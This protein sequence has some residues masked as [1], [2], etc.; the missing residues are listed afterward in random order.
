VRERR[1]GEGHWWDALDVLD[2][3]ELADLHPVL[4]I[5]GVVA[6]VLILLGFGFLVLV[7]LLLAVVDVVVLLL[8]LVV[9]GA[10]RTLLG[11]PWEVEAH[12]AGPP[13]EARSWRVRRW[14]ESSRAVEQVARRLELGVDP[15]PDL[16]ERSP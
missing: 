5:V 2:V 12:T 11:R 8:L 16:A 13:P 4:A 6:V 1:E 7:P 3:F 10:A 9:G 15:A 14:R